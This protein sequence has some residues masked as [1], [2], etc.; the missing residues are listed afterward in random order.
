MKRLKFKFGKSGISVN[1]DVPFLAWFPSFFRQMAHVYHYSAKLGENA[2]LRWTIPPLVELLTEFLKGKGL[3]GKIS[4]T[5]GAS[6]T[7]FEKTPP[8]K[9]NPKKYTVM[10]NGG[11][12]STLTLLRL[13]E[14]QG[15]ENVQCIYVPN[16]NK[17]EMHG[18][19][20]S[21]TLICGKAGV[22]L[23]VVD[24]WNSINVNKD[25]ENIGLRD[26]L[27][28]TL[29]LP[30]ILKFGSSI[31][32]FG[33]EYSDQIYQKALEYFNVHLIITGQSLKVSETVRQ[34]IE[35]W[36]EYLYLTS[37]CA[38]QDKF[39]KRQYDKLLQLHPGF[40]AYIGCGNCL[41]C[42]KIN[43]ILS[44]YT[45][46]GNAAE[47]WNMAKKVNNTYIFSF[48]RDAELTEI[49]KE[50]HRTVLKTK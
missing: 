34:L 2:I 36:P 23:I 12:K 25:N 38:K 30:H 37:S 4:M 24:A 43:G 7:Q 3:S 47:R 11:I 26:Q 42:C 1:Y 28:V 29:A 6:P 5:M 20:L 27:L 18:H 46:S 33:T 10:F 13:V 15:K 48:Q 19:L 17:N 50:L 31:V 49:V 8:P 41:E 45:Q 44:F 35:K 14:S 9:M 39:R 40:K 21:A 16:I 22:S 32:I